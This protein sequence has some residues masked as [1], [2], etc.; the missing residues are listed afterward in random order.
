M[1]SQQF[2]GARAA[3][4]FLA[5][6]V[7]MAALAQINVTTYHNDNRRTGLNPNE[8]I[9]TPA[10]V[11]GPN[12]GLLFSLPVDGQVYA[13]PL[14]LSNVN[15]PGKGLHNIVYVCTEHDSVYAFDAT[16]NNGSNLQPLWHENFGPSM[17]STDIYP[18]GGCDIYPEIGISST[19]AL[20]IV[21]FPSPVLFV[22]TKTKITELGATVYIQQL[23]ALNAATGAEM[24]GGPKLINAQAI[25]TGDGSAF[26]YV[27]FNPYYQHQRPGILLVPPVV[28]PLLAGKPNLVPQIGGTVYLGFASHGDIIPYHGW[29]LGYDA[30]KLSQ[31]VSFNTTP[32]AISGDFGGLAAGGIWQGGAGPASD[33]SSIYFATGNGAYDPSTGAYGDTI[34]RMANRTFKVADSFTPADQISLDDND[35]DEGSGGVMLIPPDEAGTAGKSLLVQAGKE[36]TIYLLDT[37]NLG[38]YNTE[39]NNVWQE[40]PSVMG[41]V[42]GAPAYFNDTIYYQPS[43]TPVVAF[44]LS[45]GYLSSSPQSYSPEYFAGYG[46]PSVSSNGSSNGIVWVIDSAPNG[47]AYGFQ[48]TTC[49]LHAY[50]ATNLSNELYNSSNNS[51]RDYPGIGVKFTTPTI[52]NGKVYVPTSNSVAVYG[53]GT[54]A[55]T[56]SISPPTGAYTGT[57]TVSISDATE[58]ATIHYTLDGSTPTPSSP[59]YRGPFN[60]STNTTVTAIA[61]IGNEEGSPIAQNGYAFKAVIGTGSGLFGAYFNGQQQYPSGYPTATEIDPVIN[62]NWNGNPPINGVAGTYWAGEWFGYIQPET[63]GT[64]TITTNSDDGVQVYING[65]PIINDY[66][67]HAPTLDTGT[68]TFVAGQLYTIEILYFQGGGGSL[69]QMWWSAPGILQQIVPTTQLYPVPIK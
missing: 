47:N 23:H 44:P 19:P 9:L 66:N 34:V 37:T 60:V 13:Q 16:N 36:G 25:G 59:I 38:G 68:Y 64:Y 5:A 8:T 69:L 51:A 12:F 6:S 65:E 20:G 7:T 26:G 39:T 58:G 4:C 53:L 14:I 31:V 1:C 55:Q 63:S 52:A 48:P 49:V 15:V 24:F 28:E 45:G 18:L 27:N 54:W 11:S 50:D 10:N 22:E 40:L 21:G 33:G 56:P 35:A 3:A 67:L 43:G 41:G 29:L 42:W 32:N 2:S 46:S 61:F 62:F 17:P 30:T 57:V